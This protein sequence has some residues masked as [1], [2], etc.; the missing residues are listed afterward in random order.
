MFVYL[1][2]IYDINIFFYMVFDIEIEEYWFSFKK[3]EIRGC[4][5]KNN[6]EVSICF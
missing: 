4:L 1:C 3:F 5:L 6:F 2:M